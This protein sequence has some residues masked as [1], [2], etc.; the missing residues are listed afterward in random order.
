MLNV[1]KAATFTMCSILITS[2][3]HS[4]Y[5][6][7]ASTGSINV[8]ANIECKFNG[9]ICISIVD[10]NNNK[11][12]VFLTPNNNYQFN[13]N[14]LQYDNYDIKDILV[15]NNSNEK[16]QQKINTKYTID[17]GDLNLNTNNQ[18]SNIILTIHSITAISNRTNIDS[19]KIK[20]TNKNIVNKSTNHI[21][22]KSLK[23]REKINICNF[24]FDTLFIGILGIIWFLKV[25]EKTD[26]VQKNISL[27]QNIYE[28]ANDNSVQ[29]LLKK[30]TNKYNEALK[31]LS[32]K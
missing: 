30:Y 27:K 7:A 24:I 4:S 1:K 32:K 26:K 8:K 9:E 19:N 28:E 16:N 14:N 18:E 13:L 2:C 3:I 29:N 5:V 20:S 17:S 31:K 10:K 6:Y 23:K 25:R 22:S 11:R 21:E 15:Y 12:F